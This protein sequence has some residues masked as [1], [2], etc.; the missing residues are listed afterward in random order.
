MTWVVSPGKLRQRVRYTTHRRSG[1][2]AAGD[3]EPDGLT[4][5]EIA[6]IPEPER[7]VVEADLPR[8]RG[9]LREH[10]DVR[11]SVRSIVRR[12]TLVKVM[13]IIVTVTGDPAELRRD[14][15]SAVLHPDP[16]QV[17]ADR[18]SSDELDEVLQWILETRMTSDT[19]TTVT[20]AGIDERAGEVV[21][22]L[23][24]RDEEYAADSLR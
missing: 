5:S 8:I 24:R 7:S 15:E 10:R 18:P 21:V 3:G 23:N 13:C 4:Q 16:L 12:S 19:R 22:T 14:I 17:R 6:A 11:A 2:S 9:W 20:T 1:S